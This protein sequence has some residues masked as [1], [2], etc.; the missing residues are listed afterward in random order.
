MLWSFRILKD[1]AFPIDSFGFPDTVAIHPPPSRQFLN[2][3][4]DMLRQLCAPDD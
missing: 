4:E 1:P 3:S 2:V